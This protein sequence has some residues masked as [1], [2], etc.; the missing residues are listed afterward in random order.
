MYNRGDFG[1][2]AVIAARVARQ[3]QQQRQMSV[4][5]SNAATA[6]LLHSGPTSQRQEQA[7]SFTTAAATNTGLVQVT[8]PLTQGH[9][10]P[11]EALALSAAATGHRGMAFNT[12]GQGQQQQPPI[13][14]SSMDAMARAAVAAYTGGARSIAELQ[15]FATMTTNN[16][17]QQAPAAA[18]PPSFYDRLG[19]EAAGFFA[20]QTLSM[21]HQHQAHQ[22]MV[23]SLAQRSQAIQHGNSNLLGP[24]FAQP[25]L[26]PG[27]PDD[28]SSPRDTKDDP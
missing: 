11:L 1:G 15:A 19:Q 12:A 17:I 27:A 28:Q 25:A 21:N 4:L 22:L 5:S 26:R 7:G 8:T 2:L 16:N 13:H 18:A 23:Q 3:Q 14:G 20:S 24:D 6:P 9:L 10:S